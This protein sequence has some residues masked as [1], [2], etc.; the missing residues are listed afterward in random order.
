MFEMATAMKKLRKMGGMKGMAAML[1]RMGGPGG[2]PLA[3]MGKLMGGGGGG[4]PG[5]M[6]PGFEKFLKR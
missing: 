3:D 1:G 4:M 2:N 6:P 5:N